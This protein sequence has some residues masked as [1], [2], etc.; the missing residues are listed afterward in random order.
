[1]LIFK[2]NTHTHKKK[3]KTHFPAEWVVRKGF[4]NIVPLCVTL[5][6]LGCKRV[7]GGRPLSASPGSAPASWHPPFH[8]EWVGTLVSLRSLPWDPIRV[9]WPSTD[10]HCGCK[11]SSDGGVWHYGGTDSNA[12]L[13]EDPSRNKPGK[14]RGP[15]PDPPLPCSVGW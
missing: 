15:G 12:T 3:I 7:M 9:G 5:K 14:C 1:M 4:T 6:K 2:N 11:D 10:N 8:L 13:E